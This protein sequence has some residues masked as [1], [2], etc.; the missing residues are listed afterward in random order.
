MK[1]LNILL[2]IC[3]MATVTSAEELSWADLVRRPELWPA[4]CTMNQAVQFEGGVSVQAGQKVDVVGF[5]ATE[6][7]IKTTDGRVNYAAGPDETDA[8]TLAREAYAKL[9]PKQRALTYESLVQQKELWPDHVTLTRTLDF[10]GGRSVRQGDQLRLMNVEPGKVLVA[11][12]TL[13]LTFRVVPQA[14]DLMAQARKFVEDPQ[15]GPRFVA[16]EKGVAVGKRA[17]GN[18]PA[19]ERV[20]GELEGKL[21][22]SVTGKPQPLDAGSLPRYLVFYR[23]SSTCPITRRFTPTLIK[24]YQEMKPK[25]PEFEIIYIMTEPVADTEKFAKE[26]GFSWRAVAYESTGAMPDVSKPI[27]GYLPQ[28]IVM[29]RN[30]KVLVNGSQNSAPTALKQLDALLKQPAEPQ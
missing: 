17:D 2:A 29:D 23:G 14:T 8:L 3:W 19:Q 25:H 21:V 10:G 18:R 20:I 1:T 13:K 9:T 22:S 5:K 27:S 16:E 15:A 7:E 11:A 12:D 4:Q 26:I 6:I 28:L 24:Y 30:G